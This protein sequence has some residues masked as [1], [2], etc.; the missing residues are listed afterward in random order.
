MSSSF[1]TGVRL[2]PR[3]PAARAARRAAS[4]TRAEAAPAAVNTTSRPVAP[5]PPGT[6]TDV[7]QELAHRPRR[8]RRSPTIRGAVRETILTPSNFLLPVFVHDGEEDIPIS[9]MPGTSRLGWRA[10][11]CAAQSWRLTLAAGAP[12]CCA[13]CAPRARR[14]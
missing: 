12:A 3:A 7:A 4:A 9:A 2:Q 5:T 13:R 8:N 14:G 11:S 10:P 6:P 1:C